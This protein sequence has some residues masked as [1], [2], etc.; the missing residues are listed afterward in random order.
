MELQIPRFQNGEVLT[1][2]QLYQLAWLP[3]NLYCL[4]NLAKGHIGFFSPQLTE[5][6]NS[7]KIEGNNLIIE[8]L[9]I[10]SDK[11]VPFILLGEKDIDIVDDAKTLIATLYIAENSRPF[12]HRSFYPIYEQPTDDDDE[13]QPNYN[14]YQIVFQWNEEP[15][16]PIEGTLSFNLHLGNIISNSDNEL[17]FEYLPAAYYLNALPELKELSDKLAQALQEYAELLLDPTI[18]V[19]LDRSRLLATIENFGD[20]LGNVY[21]PARELI[22][23]AKILLKATLGFHSWLLYA[24][25]PQD[26]LYEGIQNYRSLTERKLNEIHLAYS[27]STDNEINS[28]NTLLESTTNTGSEQVKFFQG[29]HILFAEELPSILEELKSAKPFNPEPEKKGPTTRQIRSKIN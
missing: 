28:I 6:C 1:E 5:P 13:S 21:A 16:E 22:R 25:N 3:L 14:A 23:E 26:K 2:T 11:G 9:F 19:K 7:F 24:Q 18:M 15:L 27:D 12:S 20:S 8:S 29:L 10:I 4:S 17:K